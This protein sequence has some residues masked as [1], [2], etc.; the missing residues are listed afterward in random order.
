MTKLCSSDEL[1]D[2]GTLLDPM[3]CYHDTRRLER[4]LTIHPRT[5]NL[6]NIRQLVRLYSHN[7]EA[8]ETCL[9]PD[10]GHGLRTLC[11]A[12]NFVEATDGSLNHKSL[13]FQ[14]TKE[15]LSMEILALAPE[16]HQRLEALQAA[17]QS[18]RD[19]KL[20]ELKMKGYLQTRMREKSRTLTRS[21]PEKAV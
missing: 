19:S 21:Y 18:R 5:T 1:T 11:G 16:F 17:L 13:C 4:F 8:V 9:R 2:Q 20:F 14:R 15:R 7:V 12:A 10:Q 3:T 6:A